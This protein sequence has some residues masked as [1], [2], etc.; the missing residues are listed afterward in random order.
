M[1]RVEHPKTAACECARVLGWASGVPGHD[2]VRA[3][4]GSLVSLSRT[5]QL[6]AT[7]PV[8]TEHPEVLGIVLRPKIPEPDVAKRSS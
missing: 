8:S 7:R 6:S 5:Q 3:R 1:D 2:V 4:S